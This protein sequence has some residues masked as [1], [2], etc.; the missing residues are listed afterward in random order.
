M[1]GRSAL[2][3]VN[4]KSRHGHDDFD[5][6]RA[7]LRDGGIAVDQRECPKGGQLSALITAAAPG[8][9]LV[10][11]GGGDGTLNAAL[12]GMVAVGVPLGVLPLGTA[13]DLART[14]GLP[15]DQLE[16]ARVIVAGQS[17]AIDLGWVNGKHFLNVASIGLSVQVTAELTRDLKRRWGRLGYAVG[18]WRAVRRVRPFNARIRCDQLHWSVAATQVA[19]GNGRHFGGGMIVAAE[20]R[21]DDGRLDLFA[22]EPCGLLGFV[23]LVPWLKF[24]RHGALDHVKTCRGREIDLFTPTAL[25]INTDG[26]ITTRTPGR[27]RV[28]PKAITVLVPADPEPREET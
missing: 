13:N 25:P 1:P 9:D 12:E 26:E 5:A 2:V 14:L 15:V 3:V 6:I 17:R 7:I 19:I 23:G 11:V 10:I 22:V 20:A 4:R 27:F 18:A 28:M 8:H 16:A 24:G 21:I